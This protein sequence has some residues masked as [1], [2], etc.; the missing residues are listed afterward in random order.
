MMTSIEKD[1]VSGRFFLVGCPRSGTTLLQSLLNAHAEIASFPESNF[2]NM[3]SKWRSPI[4]IAS[5]TNREKKRITNF[6]TDIGRPD[7]DDLIPKKALTYRTYIDSFIMVLDL[8]TIEQ[9][10]KYWLEKTPAHLYRIDL[11]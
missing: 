6:L 3:V 5:L 11:I 4:G 7:L 1:Q 9:G 8:L 2:F 10:A